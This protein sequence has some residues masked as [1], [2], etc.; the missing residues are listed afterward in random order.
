MALL[1]AVTLVATG[2]LSTARVATL[3]KTLGAL[4]VD[5]VGEID[6]ANEAN[7]SAS[8]AP[9]TSSTGGSSVTGS[10]NKTL[11]GVTLA[12]SA[13]HPVIG[14]LS[15]S[16]A[17]IDLDASGSVSSGSGRTANLSKSLDALGVSST[18]AA[19]VGATLSRSLGSLSLASTASLDQIEAT[20][21][22]TLDNVLVESEGIVFMPVIQ[23]FPDTLVSGEEQDSSKFTVEL[24]D[25]S[26]SSPLEGGYVF[27]RARHTREPRRTWTSGFTHIQ[28]AGKEQLEDFY[29]LVRGGSE[30]FQWK[31]PSTGEDVLV[32]FQG[33]FKFQYR[34]RGTYERWDIAFT[35]QEA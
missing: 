24:E 26:I 28:T 12:A 10:L 20:L 3:S 22:K 35:I 14:S 7:L 30:I 13:T 25:P 6:T 34:G 15:K 29:K 4:T 19:R 8:L 23:V 1:A 11:G 5:S 9:V 27:S 17:S 33:T 2:T 32:R 18:A 21:A 16:L 31:D